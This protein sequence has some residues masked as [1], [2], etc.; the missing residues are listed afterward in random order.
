LAT[1]ITKV[2]DKRILCLYFISG[3]GQ[4]LRRT[5]KELGK[6][7]ATWA[8]PVDVKSSSEGK[9]VSLASDLAVTT[10][11]NVNWVFFIEDKNKSY[12]SPTPDTITV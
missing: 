4:A 9:K 2:D 3:E 12:G 8:A 10:L 11:G 6:E 1:T 7:G 5:T